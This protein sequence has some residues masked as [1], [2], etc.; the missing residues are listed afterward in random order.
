MDELRGIRA[1]GGASWPIWPEGAIRSCRV[2][3]CNS[4]NCRRSISVQNTSRNRRSSR[5]IFLDHAGFVHLIK[6]EA[7]CIALASSAAVLA[8]QAPN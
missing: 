1:R 3:W 5:R 7:S 2:P 4:E 6:A 8:H